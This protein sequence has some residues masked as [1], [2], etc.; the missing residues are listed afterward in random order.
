[1]LQLHGELANQAYQHGGYHSF[2]ICDPKPRHI[3]K[4]AVRDRLVHHAIHRVL[5]PFF[6]GKFIADSFSCQL[7]KG[8]HRAGKRFK[9]FTGSV[10][11]NNTRT[12][13][14]LKCDIKKFFANIDQEILL[15][16]LGSSISDQGVLW[17]LQNVIG[18][19]P[20]GL[21]LGNLTSQLLVNVYMNEFDQ[22]VKHKLKARQYIRYA[23]DFVFVSEN[24]NWLEELLPRIEAF[25]TERLHLT[26]HPSKVSIETL[27][28]GVDFLGWIYFPTHAVIRTT[29]RRR[30]FRRVRERPTPETTESYLGL[31]RHGNAYKIEQELRNLNL[32]HANT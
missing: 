25:L 9:A 15:K 17:L 5:Y 11:R 19:F 22:W 7:D 10:S 27:A 16:I 20:T 28:S 1:M 31:L 29:T 32:L 4:A 3:H 14:V 30:M 21:P 26:L 23:D 2:H 13:W 12:C 18:S 8:M 24:C 6:A